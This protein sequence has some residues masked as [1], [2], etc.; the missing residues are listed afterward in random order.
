MNQ[1]RI[2]LV[3]GFW[4]DYDRT[5]WPDVWQADGD[6]VMLYRGPDPGAAMEELVRA[7][8][9]LANGVDITGEN[10][11]ADTLDEPSTAA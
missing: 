11:P 3:G 6:G 10:G 7:G 2:Q 5:R 9:G 8:A 1:W 4:L